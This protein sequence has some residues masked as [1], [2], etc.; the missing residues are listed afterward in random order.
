MNTRSA[1]F[2]LIEVMITVAIIAIL[3]AIAL[4]SYSDYVIRGKIPE[5]TTGLNAI[6][7]RMEQGYQDNRQYSAAVCDQALASLNVAGANFVF[8]CPAASLSTQAYLATA[9]GA[10][11]MLGFQYTINESG[12]RQTTKL[13]SAAWGTATINCW[14]TKKG[15][16]C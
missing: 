3:A 5:A 12:A 9:T 7:T 6:R 16:A 15:G 11:S 4:P 1:G 2:T 10:G 13:P 14:V 8:A